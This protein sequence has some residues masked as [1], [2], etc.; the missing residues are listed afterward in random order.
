MAIFGPVWPFLR[1]CFTQGSIFEL[2]K[3]CNSLGW[4]IKNVFEGAGPSMGSL[5][6]LKIRKQF[7][8]LKQKINHKSY[9]KKND[10]EKKP[11]TKSVV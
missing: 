1:C 5:K 11:Y 6:W 8:F 4:I 7:F 3:K 9:L 10:N 2:A